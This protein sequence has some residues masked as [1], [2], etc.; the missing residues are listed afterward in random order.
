MRIRFCAIVLKTEIAPMPF[1]PERRALL[2]LEGTKWS[3]FSSFPERCNLCK[4]RNLNSPTV[5]ERGGTW[6]GM[7][8]RGSTKHKPSRHC[9]CSFSSLSYLQAGI[10]MPPHIPPPFLWKPISRFHHS[11]RIGYKPENEWR[12][13]TQAGRVCHKWGYSVICFSYTSAMRLNDAKL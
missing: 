3:R 7:R 4:N 13:S 9:I 12:V 5:S 2:V 8:E 6:S 11:L 1:T 10:H